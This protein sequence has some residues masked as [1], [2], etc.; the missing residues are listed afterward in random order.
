MATVPEL[1][2]DVRF[3]LGNLSEEAISDEDMTVIIEAV[4]LKYPDNDCDQLFYSIIGVLEWLIRKGETDVAESGS[5]TERTE[6]EGNVK[7]MQKYGVTGT[8]G[9]TTGWGRILE[10]LLTNPSSIGCDITVPE[11]TKNAGIVIIG[12]T[13]KKPHHPTELNRRCGGKYNINRHWC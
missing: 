4:I 6:Q 7:I 9:V 1:I 11:D 3:F 13:A 12:T 5:V 8:D 10:D 2:A